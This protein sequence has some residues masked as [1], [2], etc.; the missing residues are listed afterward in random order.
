MLHRRSVWMPWY[1]RLASH[2]PH[3]GLTPSD[4]RCWQRAVTHCKCELEASCTCNLNYRHMASCLEQ[5]LV[6]LGRN[7][8]IQLCIG[9]EPMRLRQF[10]HLINSVPTSGIS[11]T[12]AAELLRAAD[13]DAASLMT[14]AALLLFGTRPALRAH[15]SSAQ[16]VAA[17]AAPVL[18]QRSAQ[19]GNAHAS[20][21]SSSSGS[22]RRGSGGVS[23][24]SAQVVLR[25]WTMGALSP[26]GGRARDAVLTQSFSVVAV[27][28]AA[29][30]CTHGGKPCALW[31]QLL[32]TSVNEVMA[33]VREPILQVRN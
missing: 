27:A 5:R 33:G 4:H 31:D 23:A 22:A 20:S 16:A 3:S 21:S 9:E 13:S 26:H 28:A 24:S 29:L 6:R 12:V 1:A 19:Q 32:A 15:S 7:A 30:Q 17:L 18:Q 8:T 11:D 25:S 2:G 14:V 10:V